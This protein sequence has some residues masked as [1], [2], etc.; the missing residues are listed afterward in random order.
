MRGKII[1]CSIIL[2]LFS[3]ITGCSSSTSNDNDLDSSNSGKWTVLVHFAVDNNIDYDFERYNKIVTNYLQTLENTKKMDSENSL[4]IAVML[5]CY[6]DDS[7]GTGYTSRNFVDGYY[8]LSGDFKKDF[9][10]RNG[11]WKQRDEIR[12]GDIVE[13]RDFLDYALA[14]FDSEKY[15]YSVF[16]HGGGFD[17]TTKTGVFSDLN[18]SIASDDNAGSGISGDVLT[19]YELGEITKYLKG[20]I[21]KKI[22]LFYPYACLMGGV[23]LAYEVRNNANYILFSEEVFP[24]E[25]WSYEAL[26]S[27]VDNPN[28]E[29]DELAI[30]FCKSAQSYFYDFR[31]FTLSVVD[32]AKMDELYNSINEAA[33]EILVDLDKNSNYEDYNGLAKKSLSSFYVAYYL[34]LGDFMKN[35][36]E[37]SLPERVKS[38]AKNVENALKDAVVYK[39]Y[40]N[41]FDSEVFDYGKA[42]GVTIYHNG[43]YKI[44]KYDEKYYKDV[45]DFASNK[46]YDY[47]K[48][49]NEVPISIG[50]DKQEPDDY[51]NREVLTVGATSDRSFHDAN[52]NDYFEIAL[53]SAVTYCLEL[54]SEHIDYFELNFYG[55]GFS[56]WGE[57]E[58]TLEF[59]TSDDGNYSITLRPIS[60]IGD[61]EIS[62][63]KK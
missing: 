61:Y 31:S 40:A 49:M 60:S 18:L 23:E 25:M 7:K 38:K 8:V 32:L 52:D 3:L 15:L 54:K 63:K 50:E 59:E 35:I 9:L 13:S 55:A 62:I 20:K 2:F 58:Q 4:N 28:I 36:G 56:Y 39:A 10:D 30:N 42:S 29:G 5:D 26:Q 43:W 41:D 37:S 48:K 12:S 14:K 33:S 16:N 21:G 27:V 1:N 24:A 53:D 51:E 47:V 22:D 6:G 11:T 46:W 19:H 34:D 44:Q 57:I 17:D 45:L